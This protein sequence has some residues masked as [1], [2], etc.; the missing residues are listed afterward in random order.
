MTNTE[1]ND[2]AAAV[3]EQAAHVPETASSKKGSLPDFGT[4]ESSGIPSWI[5]ARLPE[6]RCPAGK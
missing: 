2:K 6:D 3:A 1:T 4:L 5:A